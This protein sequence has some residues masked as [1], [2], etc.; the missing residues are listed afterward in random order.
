MGRALIPV[1]GVVVEGHRVASQASRDYPYGTI[2]KQKP[3][4]KALGLDLDRF[5]SGTLN[6]SIAPL[7]FEMLAPQY[8]F[9]QVAWTDLHPPE[10]F[11][12][13]ACVVRFGGKEYG[14]M[15]YYPHPETKKRHFQVASVLEILAEWIPNLSYGKRTEIVLKAEEIAILEPSN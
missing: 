14:G 11:S 9:R 15:V 13:S 2:D 8:T 3:V 7:T 5:Y 6:V 4:F 1:S 12:F 10:D